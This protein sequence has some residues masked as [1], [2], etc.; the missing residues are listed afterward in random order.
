MFQ[1]EVNPDFELVAGE[2]GAGGIVGVAEIY[3]VRDITFRK[4][5]NEAVGGSHR[6]VLYLAPGSVSKDAGAACHHVG[7]DIYGIYR[8]GHG[9]GVVGRQYVAEIAGVAFAPSLTKISEG[10]MSIPRF[11]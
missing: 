7:V 8:V 5:G 6:K 2:G 1:R 9:H 4:L 3:Y 10:S 11:L